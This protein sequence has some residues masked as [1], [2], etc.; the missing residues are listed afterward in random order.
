MRA[1][2]LPS[3]TVVACVLAAALVGALRA[4]A[5][6]ARVLPPTPLDSFYE[7]HPEW[8][9]RPGGGYKPYH[10]ARWFM[11]A[12][13]GPPGVS[14][15]RL[16]AEAR[17]EGTTRA[18][19]FRGTRPA[20]FSTGPHTLSGRCTSIAF[21]PTDAGVVYVGTAG[22][23]LWKSTDAGS[24]WAPLTDFETS[25]SIG[26][27]AVLPW[28]P[29]IVLA[30]TGDGNYVSFGGNLLDPFGVGMLRSTNAGATWNPT[31][32]QYPESG[33]HG[34]NAIAPGP[35][36][37]VLAG[38]ND[39]LWR[40]TDDGATWTRTVPAGNIMDVAWKPG[41]ASRVYIAKCNDPFVTSIADAGVHVSTDAGLTFSRVGTGQ[42]P[43]GLVG[44]TRLATTPAD[45]AYVYANVVNLTTSGTLGVYRSTDD[46]AT[47][48]PRNATLNMTA[49]QGWFDV[50]LVADPDDAE[51]ILAGGVSLYRS[52]NGGVVL[53]PV[54]NVFPQGDDANPHVDHHAAVYEPGSS[55]N[56]W[57]A[58]DGG[59]WRSTD[60]GS[61]WSSRRTGI[62]S[63]QFYDVCVAQGPGFFAMGGTQDNGS[64]GRSAQATWFGPTLF[65]DGSICNVSPTNPN[66]VYAQQ[67][68]S[69]HFKSVNGGST[70]QAINQGLPGGVT[71]IAPQDEDPF[72]GNHL[73]TEAS[74]GI[75][76]TTN[77]GALWENVAPQSA[78][79][80][81]FSRV[82]GNTVWTTSSTSWGTW[83]TTDDGASWTLASSFPS[84]GFET[85]IRTHPTDAET[86]F[87][88]F[89]G[90]AT[91]LPK[92]LRTTDLGASWTDVSGDL[93]D[94]PVSTFIADPASPDAWFVGTDAG[95]WTSTDGG[96]S[97]TPFGSD[98]PNIIVV[99]LE[100]QSD[101]ALP[102]GRKLVAATY[103]RGVWEV[104][105]PSVAVDAPAPAPPRSRSL[106]LDAPFPNP[107]RGEAVL[108]WAARSAAPA[109]L[110]IVDV[111]GRRV[112]VIVD[113]GRGDGLVR[114]A[115]WIADDVA[116]GVYF[117]VLSAGEEF[118]VRRVVIAR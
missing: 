79:S 61:T 44:H 64:V 3:K 90:Y 112:A 34:F 81:A 111:T 97:W 21:D 8:T 93:P 109:R 45:P 25:L 41:S 39:G 42:P 55:S 17:D 94:V 43:S 15:A 52:T 30:G 118:V 54:G 70:W 10:R 28:N 40:S 107:S 24:S 51:K 11:E 57:V 13:Q 82:D 96:A 32:L 117:A 80:I 65:G 46:G 83:V 115:S 116:A 92:V 27:V 67:Q 77:G 91:G 48:S 74:G 38:A 49:A 18:A 104:D 33:T 78:R 87:V 16:R 22:G 73:Y 56:V 50:S 72:V 60:D 1:S 105:L 59:V 23:G 53:Q 9:S 102:P 69:S 86:A 58:C 4:A 98:L 100:I 68:F 2:S 106:M 110:E 5:E 66:V 63:F 95:V 113:Q 29:S 108:R 36:G 85:Q 76:R 84:A 62:V 12:R 19:R 37:T 71:F 114:R 103:G 14:T 89:G 26:A 31:S 101:G 6:E 35:S 7:E 75:Y 99:D 20:W 88:T 47:W